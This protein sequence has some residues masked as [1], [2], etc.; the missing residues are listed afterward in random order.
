MLLSIALA[1]QM[2]SDEFVDGVSD[3]FRPRPT[4][5]RVP[6]VLEEDYNV[7]F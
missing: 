5:P 4:P 7:S 6:V 2:N 1:Q 3:G